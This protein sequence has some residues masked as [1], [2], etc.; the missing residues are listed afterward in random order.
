MAAKDAERIICLQ[1]CL[2]IAKNTLESIA[3]NDSY[4]G[5]KAEAALETIQQ[6][7]LKT[8]PTPLQGL[9]GHGRNV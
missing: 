6:E 7:E 8:K 2:K 5:T 1:K 4:A 3:Y 9:V